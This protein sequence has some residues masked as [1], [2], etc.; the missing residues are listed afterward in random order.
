[1][2]FLMAGFDLTGYLFLAPYL[3]SHSAAVVIQT[4]MGIL[5]LV[6]FIFGLAGSVSAAERWS[7]LLSVV[8]ASLVACWGLLQNWYTLTWLTDQGD[9]QRGITFGTIAIFFSLL[10]IILVVASKERFKV[11]LL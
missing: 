6:A 11:R 3:V 5:A 2:M 1:M 10:V 4:Y 7:L 9:I 8:G